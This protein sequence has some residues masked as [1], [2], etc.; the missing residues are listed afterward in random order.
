MDGVDTV[1]FPDLLMTTSRTPDRVVRETVAALFA[2]PEVIGRVPTGQLLNRA[3]AIFTEPV[4]L[5][6]AALEY[7]REEKIATG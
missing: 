7:F 5:H 1:A 6:E 4:P 3:E 2:H